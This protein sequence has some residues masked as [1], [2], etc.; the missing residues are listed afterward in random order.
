MD[1]GQCNHNSSGLGSIELGVLLSSVLF[2]IILIQTYKYYQASFK[3]DN[4][5][6]K[7]IVSLMHLEISSKEKLMIINSKV[8]SLWYFNLGNIVDY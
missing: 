2:G 8:G 7:C 4:I 5:I 1:S 3:R 6:L